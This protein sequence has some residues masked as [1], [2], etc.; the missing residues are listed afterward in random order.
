MKGLRLLR[1]AAVAAMV[2]AG[3]TVTTAP[4][5]GAAPV[6]V[7]TNYRGPPFPTTTRA[8]PGRRRVRLGPAYGR[9]DRQG[10]FDMS[11]SIEGMDADGNWTGPI[12]WRNATGTVQVQI[13]DR[14]RTAQV[15]GW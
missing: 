12:L 15:S 5:A 9:T 14:L 4:V 1:P 2:V 7:T 10:S 13:D 8:G 6:R 3:L 11:Q